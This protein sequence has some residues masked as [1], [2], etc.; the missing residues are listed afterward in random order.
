MQERAIHIS[1]VYSQKIGKNRAEDF[2]IK[3][4]P[5]LNL[6][7]YMTHELALDKVTMTYS[8]H[9]ISD[10]YKNNKIKYLTDGGTSWETVPFIDGMYTYSDLNDYLYQYMKKKGHKTTGPKK[11]MYITLT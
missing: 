8:W 7:N 1:S 6:Q 11:T 9:N 4:D 2:I 5:V 10:Q 3:F